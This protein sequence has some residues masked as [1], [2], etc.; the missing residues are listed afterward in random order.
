[1]VGIVIRNEHNQHDKPVGISFRRK[2][3]ISSDVIWSVLEKVSQSNSRF[4]ATDALVFEVHAVKMPVGFGKALKMMG[5]QLVNLVHL[6]RS[7]VEVQAE[8]DCL[9]HALIIAVARVNN[10]PNY[11]AYRQGRKLAPK[12]QHLLETTGIR[13][14]EGGGGLQELA[15]FQKY[16][17]DYRI[18]VYAGLECGNIMYDGGVPS[19]KRLNLLYDDV[20][21]HYHV[22]VNLPGAMAK[23]YV[24]GM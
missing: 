20:T 16:F 1:M 14:D 19:S 8:K 10:D 2:D 6:K 18:V 17:K 5:R 24:S 11:K 9:A 4:N 13:L 12:V 3:Q 23:R 22:L 21:R 15:Q 7:I